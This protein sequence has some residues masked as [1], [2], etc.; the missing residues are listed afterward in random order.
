[1]ISK[2]SGCESP[3]G[4][5]TNVLVSGDSAVVEIFFQ[6]VAKNGWKFEQEMCFVCKYEKE[7]C[8]SVRMYTDSAAE[9]KLFDE[10]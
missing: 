8:V 6:A 3:V 4:K 9:A 1:V 10:N 2:F 7:I 5:I